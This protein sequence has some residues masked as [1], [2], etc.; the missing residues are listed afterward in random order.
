MKN[1]TVKQVKEALQQSWSFN[2]SSKWSPINPAKGQ[3]G[4]TALVVHD[5]LGG[6]IKKTNMTYGWH[7][8]NYINEKRYDFTESQF[9]EPIIYLDIQ[10]NRNEA[11]SDTNDS[12]YNYLKSTVLAYLNT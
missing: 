8:Y 3:C 2:S 4:V 11:F 1:Y 9:I 5:L 10:S 7:Y 12:Q 6:E